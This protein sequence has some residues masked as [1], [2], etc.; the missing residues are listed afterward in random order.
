MVFL[1][2]DPV[3][4]RVFFTL[5]NVNKF[6]VHETRKM[7]IFWEESYTFDSFFSTKFKAPKR[8][9]I[10]TLHSEHDFLEGFQ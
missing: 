3:G 10:L 6:L 7:P 2:L 8:L 1:E 5:T 4:S 9:L